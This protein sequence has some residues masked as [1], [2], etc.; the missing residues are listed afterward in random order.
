[1]KNESNKK[2]NNKIGLIRSGVILFVLTCLLAATLTAD[3]WFF[4]GRNIFAVAEISNPTIISI[5]AGNVED[6]RYLNL[7]GIDVSNGT[8]KDFVFCVNGTNID[9]YKLQLAY[10]TNNQFVYEIYPATLLTSGEVPN[11]SVGSVI[12][13]VH[14]GD[15]AGTTQQYY[16]PS[17][18][19]ALP[20]AF[21][22]KDD[23]AGEILAKNSD[24][25]HN[26]TYEGYTV[27][28]DK[29]AIPLYWQT[30][31]V[32]RGELGGDFEHYYILRVIWTSESRNSK[33]TDII[34]ISAKNTAG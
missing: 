19:S 4:Y 10:T 1:M 3:A 16:I 22:N 33:E 29:Y 18:T 7:S 9:T 27:Y 15:G 6:I 25:Y 32:I 20:G 34:Y 28:R 23:E 5:N 2:P 24:T 14:V 31:G 12:Y 11:G 30:S 21:L 26:K 13:N 17:G 8:Y